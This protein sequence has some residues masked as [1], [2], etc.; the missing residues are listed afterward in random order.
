MEVVCGAAGI[1][2]ASIALSSSTT[3]FF[4]HHQAPEGRT[5]FLL[6]VLSEA[7]PSH[8]ALGACSAPPALCLYHLPSLCG[9]CP[10]DLVT[11]PLTGQS[12]SYCP[13]AVVQAWLA[14]PGAN[15]PTCTQT[16]VSL[17]VTSQAQALSSLPLS[18]VFRKMCG[19]L[20]L[21]GCHPLAHPL[22]KLLFFER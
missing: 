8:C 12:P 11:L 13:S 9:H 18:A 3:F 19:D 7:V 21:S 10:E 6:T 15:F 4:L 20:N 1:D 14:G 5:P 22:T 2:L 17:L 16:G